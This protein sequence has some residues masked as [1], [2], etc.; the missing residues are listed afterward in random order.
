MIERTRMPKKNNKSDSYNSC[1][2]YGYV[3]YAYRHCHDGFWEFVL[4]TKNKYIHYVNEYT[5]TQNVNTVILVRP[6]DGHYMVAC[7]PDSEYFNLCITDELLRDFLNVFNDNLY[8]SLIAKPYISYEL[9]PSLANFIKKTTNDYFCNPTGSFRL[10]CYSLLCSLSSIIINNAD[11]ITTRRYSRATE[12][13]LALFSDSANLALQLKELIGKTHYSY[14]RMNTVFKQEVGV[15]PSE[16]L[17]KIRLD[18]AKKMLLH[19]EVKCSEIAQ[20]IGYAT[21]S[22]FS[23]YFK[24]QTGYTPSGFVKKYKYN[25]N[26]AD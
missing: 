18:Y 2:Y 13:L 4:P 11:N 3:P 12:A 25:G 1:F 14:S 21:P 8:D 7:A 19:S 9:P 6:D 20:N 10:T 16:Y 24:E 26:K 15:S 23:V 22:R 17:K 5:F